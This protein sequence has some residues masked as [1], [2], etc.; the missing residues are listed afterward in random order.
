MNSRL[1]HTR[2]SLTRLGVAEDRWAAAERRTAAVITAAATAAAQAAAPD[3]H[4]HLYL[5]GWTD[6]DADRHR[7]M[8][9]LRTMAD[10]ERRTEKEGLT[11]FIMVSLLSAS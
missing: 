6:W 2:L 9:E 3:S 8:S 4:R 11:R 7:E 1:L 5:L 10:G